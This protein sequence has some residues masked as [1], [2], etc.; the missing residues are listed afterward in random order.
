MLA[1]AF[2]PAYAWV[3]ARVDRMRL[4]SIV[5]MF[6][7]V[8]LVIF[9]MIGLSGG[10]VG[11]VFFVWTGLFSLVMVAQFWAFA[12]DVY[13]PERGKRLFPLVGVGQSLGGV[14]GA[15][16]AVRFAGVNP[17]ALMLMAAGGLLL[18]LGLTLWTNRRERSGGRDRAAAAADAPIGRRN[19]FRMVFSDRYLFLIAMLFVVLNLVNTLGGFLLDRLIVEESLRQVAANPGADQG[20]IISRLSG[21][22]QLTVNILGFL[23]QMFAVSRIF[24]LIG[25]RG[26][27]FVLPIL[28][29][30]S[31]G[32]I[33]LVPIFAV[34]RIAKILENS[35]DYSIQ[36]T[37]RH[38]LFLPTSREAKYKA[39]QA[40]DSFFVRAGDVIQAII[41]FTGERLT[42]AVPAF[43]AINVVLVGAWL[44]VAALLNASREQQETR[45]ATVPQPR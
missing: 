11:I 42:L 31:Y 1:L 8:N 19:G 13:T 6:F 14:A 41:V 33:T 44:A 4:I 7:A 43:A 2:V 17:Y 27:L 10:R 5:T 38:A 16:V 40:V 21:G 18:P 3:A 22:V 35:T 24:K 39:K 12:N 20:E 9:A 23:L 34:V 29:L 15:S 25:V 28:A 26:A 45:P 32:M 30:G 37:T 36:Q